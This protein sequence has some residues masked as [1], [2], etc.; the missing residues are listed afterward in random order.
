VAIYFSDPTVR[1]IIKI[2]RSYYGVIHIRAL[3]G[4]QPYILRA[5]VAVLIHDGISAS[6]VDYSPDVP[7]SGH[8]LVD[9][10]ITVRVVC[11]PKLYNKPFST[12][13]SRSD[14]SLR[15]TSLLLNFGNSKPDFSFYPEFALSESH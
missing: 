11:V 1:R 12:G 14:C 10:R 6:I 13:G 2:Y 15:V 9:G 7:D 8:L 5:L 4:G 3:R